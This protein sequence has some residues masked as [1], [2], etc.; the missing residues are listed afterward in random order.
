[1]KYAIIVGENGGYQTHTGNVEN[2]ELPDSAE[3]YDDA[4]TFES[5]LDELR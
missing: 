3:I 4:E 5:R 2:V 1:M